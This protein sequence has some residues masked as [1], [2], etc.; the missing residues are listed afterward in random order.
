MEELNLL[1]Y[2][3]KQRQMS[4]RKKRK[5][6]FGIFLIVM[7]LILAFGIPVF[8]YYNSLNKDKIAEL[9]LSDKQI[10]NMKN[11][12]LE[13]AINSDKM[14][15]KSI[16]MMTSEKYSTKDNIALFQTFMTSDI[17]FESFSY[18]RQGV[19]IKGNAKYYNSPLEFAANMQ[20]SR[21]FADVKLLNVQVDKNGIVFAI[22]VT[23]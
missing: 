11:K 6:F 4:S 12:K 18:N 17:Y 1:P 10:L 14:Y 23:Y 15:L 16:D 9:Q 7:A 22:S 13:K 3:L 21:K 8:L 19:E 5:Y 20:L 2:S